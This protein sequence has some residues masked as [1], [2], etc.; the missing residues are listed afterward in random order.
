[1]K[2]GLLSL[3]RRLMVPLN[4]SAGRGR[5]EAP[6]L[7]ALPFWART[8]ELSRPEAAA[9]P[10]RAPAPTRA[11]A[12][13]RARLRIG[14][15][16]WERAMIP[17][18]GCGPYSRRVLQPRRLGA[19]FFV[20]SKRTLSIVPVNGNLPLP[21]YAGSMGVIESRPTSNGSSPCRKSE[22]LIL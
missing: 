8:R 13:N 3:A 5:T 1:G 16:L 20:T 19:H 4:G 7:G 9:Q 10:S 21:L 6:P 2:S 18:R 15:L 12:V 11:A 22:R 17:G 14:D